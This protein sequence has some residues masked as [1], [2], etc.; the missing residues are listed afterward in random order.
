MECG[1]CHKYRKNSQ[2]GN[3]GFGPR[4]HVPWFPSTFLFACS[5]FLLLFLFSCATAPPP[6]PPQSPSVGQTYRVMG[7]TYRVMGSSKGFVQEGSAS[8]YGPKFHGK[9]TASGEVYDMEKFT[10]AHRTLPLGTYVKVKRTDGK[11]ETVV[12]KINDRGPF[13][14]NR[15]IDVS[16][17]AARQLEMLDEGVA[18]VLITALGEEV[19]RGK[20]DEITLRPRYDYGKGA[21]SVQVGAFTVRE[22]AQRLAR[23]MKEDHGASDLSLYDRGDAKF[24]RVRVGRFTT[25]EEA[26]RFLDRLIASGEF[27]SGF[28]VAR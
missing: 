25:S 4:G 5:L 28:V 1:T 8:W 20:P 14:D 11:G 19:L 24:F 18:P 23:R 10:A 7:Q 27:D 21:F 6:P 22:N 16:R 13:V 15:A 12:V 2:D 17:A 26:E 9:R 3:P